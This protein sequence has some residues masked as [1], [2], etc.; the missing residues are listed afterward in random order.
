MSRISVV[1]TGYVG[2]VT[3]ACFADL[4][5]YVTCIDVDAEKI[6]ALR[7]GTIPFYEPGLEEV[8]ARNVGAGRLFF[9]ESY[10]EGLKDAELVFIAVNTPPGLSGEADLSYARAA[11]SSAVDHLR[12]PAIF[13]GKSTMPIGS[14]DGANRALARRG[15]VGHAIVSNPEFLREGSAVADFMH[16]DRVVIG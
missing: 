1:G 3:G 9:T 6:G 2:L 16:P 7:Q 11:F 12:T 4:G 13:V 5:N 15:D 10:A 8:V 14:G